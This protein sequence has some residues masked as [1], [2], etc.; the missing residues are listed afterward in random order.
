MTD[1]YRLRRF[2]DIF[3]SPENPCL[4]HAC[5]IWT[6]CDLSVLSGGW[7]QLLPYFLIPKGC[8]YYS[9]IIVQYVW[10]PEGVI[11]FRLAILF[12]PFGVGFYFTVIIYNHV[13]PSGFFSFA[14]EIRDIYASL[15][16][17]AHESFLWKSPYR[18]FKSAICSNVSSK[19]IA[20]LMLN[21]SR[22]FNLADWTATFGA[23]IGLSNAK[24]GNTHPTSSG[25]AQIKKNSNYSA[26]FCDYH[27]WH[28]MTK[29][30][31][32]SHRLY[33]HI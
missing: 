22:R 16:A 24:V 14:N 1:A 2:G 12:H 33:Y 11:C 7:R 20:G 26:W 8:N 32:C 15:C 6:L 23:G 18:L 5:F 25:F 10:N 9:N 29:N 31:K 4:C 19:R 21:I 30:I 28:K 27:I 13:I 3:F 17:T